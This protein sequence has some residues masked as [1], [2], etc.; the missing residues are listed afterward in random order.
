LRDG[1]AKATVGLHNKQFRWGMMVDQNDEIVHED[2]LECS[3]EFLEAGRR[4]QLYAD[5]LEA[6]G[7]LW[8]WSEN[9]MGEPTEPVILS[10]S[11]PKLG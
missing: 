1:G 10:G 3:P 7:A 6:R 9:E 4:G 2:L 11:Q 5:W 8:F